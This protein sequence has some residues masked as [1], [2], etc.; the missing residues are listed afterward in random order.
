MKALLCHAFGEPETLTMGTLESRAPLAGEVRI[1]VEACGVNYTDVVMVQGQYQTKPPFPFSP[2]LEVAGE[3]L[4]VGEGVTSV[5]PGQPVMA[6][7]NYGGMAEEVCTPAGLVIPRPA[8]MSAI[9]G[10]AFMVSYGTSHV[11]LA[12]RAQM[13]EGETLLVLG[14]GGGTGLTAVEIGKHMGATVIAC[15]STPEKLAQ[16]GVTVWAARFQPSSWAFCMREATSAS[17]SSSTIMLPQAIRTWA[18][19]G[20]SNTWPSP[21]SLSP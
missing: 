20:R 17:K 15:A 5:T 2:G 12:H 4:E 21:L 14:A 13:L 10:A 8:G 7:L 16:R 19:S 1:R 11:A 18:S 9:D 6:L 3:V